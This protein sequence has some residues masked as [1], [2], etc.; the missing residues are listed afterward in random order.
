M[1][2]FENIITP[3]RLER[4][5]KTA[6]ARTTFHTFILE[7]VHKGHNVGAILRSLDGFGFQDVY[8]LNDRT[9][10]IR[11]NSVAK[12]AQKWLTLHRHQDV[13]ECIQAVKERGYRIA[14]TTGTGKSITEVDWSVPTAIVM[15]AEMDGIG[16]EMKEASDLEIRIPMMGLTQSFNVSVA[17]ACIAFY[18]RQALHKLP[19]SEWQLTSAQQR[20]LI[21][22][23]VKSHI[24]RV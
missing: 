11:K 15:G 5:Q 6:A 2:S 4:L 19:P 21:Q 20:N 13:I 16:P 3:A 14:I 24:E 9:N 7:E 10:L 18:V 12:G 8:T 17:T 23:W 1:D 22:S